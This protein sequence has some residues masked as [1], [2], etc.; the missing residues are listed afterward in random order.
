MLSKD[1]QKS[2]DISLQNIFTSF[3]EDEVTSA[4]I[5]TKGKAHADKENNVVVVDNA[6]SHDVQVSHQNLDPVL[7]GDTE[8]VFHTDAPS[9]PTMV[10][11]SDPI[12]TSSFEESKSDNMDSNDL[13]L[14][15]IPF[16]KNK[17]WQE[18][19]SKKQKKATLAQYT[20]PATRASISISQ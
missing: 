11:H 18:V 19:Q 20:R 7:V 2:L 14:T 10:G 6:T 9:V 16:S 13:S 3:F 8:Q 12:D 4:D 1:A 15:K 5:L 17:G